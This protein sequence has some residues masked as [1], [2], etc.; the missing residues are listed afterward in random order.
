V[1][2]TSDHTSPDLL[3]VYTGVKLF[4]D[5]AAQRDILS[6]YQIQAMTDFG[7][8]LWIIR[9]SYNAFDGL[10]E[11]EIGQLV[12]GQQCACQGATVGCEDKDFLFAQV[13]S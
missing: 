6:S 2:D 3:P 7:T 13:L 10:V 8:W 1:F 12:A 9:G 11:D 4:I 5:Q